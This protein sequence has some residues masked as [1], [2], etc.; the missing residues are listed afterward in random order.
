M[1]SYRSRMPLRD[2]TAWRGYRE[3][4]WIPVRIGACGGE[5]LQYD[6]TRTRFV[7][8]DG[9]SVAIDSVYVDGQ[10]V[11]AFDWRNDVDST[12]R[13]VT[14][15]TFAAPVAEGKPVIARGRGRP[16]S[17]RGG[18]ADNAADALYETLVVTG[19][20]SIS[21]ARL[22]A[23]RQQCAGLPVGGSIETDAPLFEVARSI[24]G[25]IGAICSP[26]M[27]GFAMLWPGAAGAAIATIERDLGVSVSAEAAL[28]DVCTDLTLR[29]AFES[30][31][32]RGAVQYVVATPR[33]SGEQPQVVEAPFVSSPRV[34][35]LVCERLLQFRARR[36]WVVRAT[37]LRGDIRIG[38]A[39]AIDHPL[40]PV[41]GT[42]VVLERELST[43]ADGLVTSVTIRAPVGAAPALRL[44]RNSSASDALPEITVPAS[45]TGDDIEVVVVDETQRPLAGAAC[46]LDGQ[47]TR[48]ADNA[49]LVR[50]PGRYAT[51]GT[52]TIVATVA[53]RP[54]VTISLTV[55]GA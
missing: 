11:T 27:R 45:S 26:D 28:D 52:H 29:Y 42:H 24:C 8:A 21:D 36:Q 18:L 16:S 47:V 40:S 43:D 30:G 5:A 41:T 4:R 10:R 9:P 1:R 37:G 23:F 38:Q 33:A 32:P 20:L 25:S 55:G 15:I 53:G 34:A 12:G 39:V 54:P 50:F 48:Y 22:A 46:T 19:G 35:A 2:T 13:V 51:P 44:V 14:Y 31:T 7:W 3:A 49:G 6:E 17:I